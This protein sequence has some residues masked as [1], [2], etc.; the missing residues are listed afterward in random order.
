M[1]YKVVVSDPET[2]K[3]YQRE[4]RDEAAR[5]LVGLK[6]GSELDGGLLGLAGYRLLV[7]GGSDRSGFPMRKGV[8][9]TVRSMVLTR[10]G[11]G[12]RPVR[13]ERI[14]KRLRGEVVGED[15]IQINTKVVKKGGTSIEEAFGIKPV[16][17]QEGGGAS[18]GK[19]EG[20]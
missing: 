11:V 18:P 7:T 5:R 3:S 10:G 14:R 12:Y 4:V 8:H 6:V 1:D 17:K 16:E 19:Q 13:E 20:V 9:G 2:G 15:V